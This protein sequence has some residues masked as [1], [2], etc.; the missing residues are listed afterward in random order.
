MA[1]SRERETG[2]QLRAARCAAGL[3]QRQLAMVLAVSPGTIWTWERRS[4]PEHRQSAVREWTA[5]LA[6]SLTVVRLKRLPTKSRRPR[7]LPEADDLVAELFNANVRAAWRQPVRVLNAYLKQH[8]QPYCVG[9]K[10]AVTL[11]AAD[12]ATFGVLPLCR[13]C[14]GR[15][16]VRNPYSRVLTCWGRIVNGTHE[17]CASE[18]LAYD[19]T[20]ATRTPAAPLPGNDPQAAWV[21]EIA[22]L[23]F[24]AG[25]DVAAGPGGPTAPSHLNT[26]ALVPIVITDNGRTSV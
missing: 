26:A 2:R 24:R 14:G 17:R 4:V 22:S 12:M 16:L 19:D 11:R 8:G 13:V 9:N 18:S 23:L 20:A 25:D 15:N 10:S 21:P 5:R 1:P 7:L 3:S 6:T